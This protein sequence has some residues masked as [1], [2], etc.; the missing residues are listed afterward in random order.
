MPKF[1]GENYM[2]VFTAYIKLLRKKPDISFLTNPFKNYHINEF[3]FVF[4]LIRNLIKI[5]IVP[6]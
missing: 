4:G 2:F 1:I 5:I 3:S 6:T